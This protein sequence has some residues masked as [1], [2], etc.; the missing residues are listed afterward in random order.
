VVR[1]LDALV[2]SRSD[3]ERRRL[4]DAL[5]GAGLEGEACATGPDCLL[6]LEAKESAL[7]VVDLDGLE[8]DTLALLR[9]LIHQPWQPVV[10]AVAASERESIEALLEGV[11]VCLDRHAG[12]GLIAAQAHALLRR[13]QRDGDVGP[14][15]CA[16]GLKIDLGRCEASA[17]DRP[18]PLTPTEFRLLA[19]LAGRP[20]E[21][22][23]SLK[24][25]SEC[26]ITPLSEAE[27]RAT[28][29]VHIHR[30]RQKIA[31]CGGNPA[32]VRNVRSFGYMLERRTSG[33]TYGAASAPGQASRAQRGA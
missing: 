14:V 24:L 19:A 30:I 18:I 28:A 33:R 8:S 2:I 9:R 22:V 5:E 1:R 4:V 20:G 25:L 17:D 16:G 27:A 12:S 6:R 26:A 21:V 3:F 31:A 29:K 7:V 15:V 11:D 23:G 10:I 13:R 32:V